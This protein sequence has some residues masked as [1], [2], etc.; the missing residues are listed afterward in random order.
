MVVFRPW[1]VEPGSVPLVDVSVPARVRLNCR[2]A[3]WPLAASDGTF[4]RDCALEKLES[5]VLARIEVLL[6]EHTPTADQA[7]L[8]WVIDTESPS[9]A[10]L[11]LVKAVIGLADAPKVIPA[12][13]ASVPVL[14]RLT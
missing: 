10:M 12:A 2:W 14:F 9:P 1:I 3:S 11:P 7:T 13:D 5:W 6:P 8:H 4:E